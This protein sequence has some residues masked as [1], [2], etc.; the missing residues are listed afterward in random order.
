MQ[1]FSI[2]DQ[3][4]GHHAIQDKILCSF[5][6]DRMAHA[7][8]LHGPEGCGK[9]AF[10]ISIAKL[11]NCAGGDGKI[12]ETSPAYAK[13]S[14]L[15]HPDVKFIFPIP[16]ASNRK[17]GEVEE[18]LMQ[19]AENP[20]LRSAFA[21]KNTFIGIDTI[22]DI[23]K[24]A[25]YKLYEGRRKVFIISQAETMRNE[26]ANALLKL[27]EEPPT[28]LVIILT[29]ENIHQILPTIKSRCQLLRFPRLSQSELEEIARANKVSLP[30]DQLS[31]LIRLSGHNARRLFDFADQDVLA[32]RD[33]AIDLLR[34]IVVMHRAQELLAMLE[35]ITSGRDRYRARLLIWFLSLWFQDI[36]HL[37][38]GGARSP[39]H[40]IDKSE[41][42][43][44]F[45]AF[46]PNSDIPA[47]VETLESAMASLDDPRNFNPLLILTHLA[48]KLNAHIKNSAQ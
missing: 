47:I 26:A 44:K 41:T 13:I 35:D 11:L 33:Q 2:F 24:E 42:L 30:D 34:K 4:I 48:V 40:N 28:N 37:R 6:T 9:D 38:V 25:R 15:Q 3:N 31:L 18:V 14:H 8:L 7:Y 22:R 12:D 1:T 10:A 17:A 36:L 21:G 29:T 23:K 20:Y 32:M 46:T 19:K 5:L 27:L 43:E 16:A 39:V 45:M